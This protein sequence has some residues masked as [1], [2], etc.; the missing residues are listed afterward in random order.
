MKNKGVCVC[1]LYVC[2]GRASLKSVT[3]EFLK[4]ISPRSVSIHGVNPLSLRGR[5]AWGCSL[6]ASDRFLLT[7]CLIPGLLVHTHTHARGALCSTQSCSK[8]WRRNSWLHCSQ[9][10]Q[11]P[12]PV[13]LE[14]QS[15]PR[16]Q[17]IMT[18]KQNQFGDSLNSPSFRLKHCNS[19][20]CCLFSLC[21]I[22]RW[23]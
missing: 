14:G 12:G 22:S 5:Y 3:V 7:R 1:V 6:S 11:V 15:H 20:S 21:L 2:G 8:L 10:V 19:R 23:A 18:T 17:H 16:W 13:T 9:S 4:I